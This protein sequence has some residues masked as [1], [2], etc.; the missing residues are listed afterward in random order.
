MC[1]LLMSRFQTSRSPYVNPSGP[2][3]NQ[4]EIR[5]EGWDP[6]CH[7]NCLLPREGLYLCKP[8]PLLSPSPSGTGP[9]IIISLPFLPDFPW[10]FLTAL[11]VQESSCQSPVSF[12]WD[13]SMF[14]YLLDIFMGGSNF[15]V[16]LLCHP[17]LFLYTQCNMSIYLNK[18]GGSVK[19]R[20][21]QQLYI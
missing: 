18:P 8:P 21:S 13:F 15:C 19:K 5:S 16:L 6:M 20:K 2:P 12:Q 1:M 9:D 10:I 11:V 14:I 17:D 4:E 3:S 7:S